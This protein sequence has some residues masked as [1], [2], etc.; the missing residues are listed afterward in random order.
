MIIHVLHSLSLGQL[1][2]FYKG[3]TLLLVNLESMTSKP[4]AGGRSKMC[5][6]WKVEKAMHYF[7]QTDNVT[8]DSSTDKEKE[9]QPLNGCLIWD[10]AQPFNK[11]HRKF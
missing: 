1:C 7:V 6:A 5:V 4:K 10:V 11:L 2:L 9:R 3:F 8:T